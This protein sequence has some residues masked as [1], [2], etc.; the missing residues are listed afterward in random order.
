MNRKSGRKR[1]VV[2]TVS[3]HLFLSKYIAASALQKELNTE[4]FSA[5]LWKMKVGK[6]TVE[7]FS[8]LSI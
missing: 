5:G 1:V 6:I 2:N 4:N 8:T 7:G 3:T